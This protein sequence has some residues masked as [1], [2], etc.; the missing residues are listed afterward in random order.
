[1]THNEYLAYH[2]NFNNNVDASMRI[3]KNPWF[4]HFFCGVMDRCL[5]VR[6]TEYLT[7]VICPPYKQLQ[8]LYM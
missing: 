4:Q 7:G 3:R 1:M 8:L 6:S 5:F 2:R